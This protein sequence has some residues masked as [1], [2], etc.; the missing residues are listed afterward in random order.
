MKLKTPE[1]D[2]K[3]E[4]AGCVYQAIHPGTQRLYGTHALERNAM[5]IQLV[6]R[7]Y[8]CRIN[9]PC[10]LIDLTCAE[11]GLVL[12]GDKGLTTRGPYL[13]KHYIGVKRF[14]RPRI[15]FGEL[16]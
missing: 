9:E 3:S 14:S 1:S 16:G 2:D 13:N 11:L 15:Q 10:A 4:I 7:M 8:A 6:P 5:L 12:K